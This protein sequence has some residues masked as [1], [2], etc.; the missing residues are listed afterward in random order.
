MAG[1]STQHGLVYARFQNNSLNFHPFHSTF[2]DP[3]GS[4]LIF[5]IQSPTPQGPT[6]G[7]L[8]ITN[9]LIRVRGLMSHQNLHPTCS[10]SHHLIVLALSLEYRHSTRNDNFICVL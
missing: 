6:A 10:H 2:Q 5:Q 9:G 3:T 4:A 7:T 1:M 8:T